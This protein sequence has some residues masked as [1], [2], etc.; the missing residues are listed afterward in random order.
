MLEFNHFE[1]V[2]FDGYGTL[3]DWERGI[4]LVLRQLLSSRE[5]DFGKSQTRTNRIWGDTADQR[6]V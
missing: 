5:I 2:S 1:V 4:L 3:I 6:P